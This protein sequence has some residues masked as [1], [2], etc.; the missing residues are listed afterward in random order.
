MTEQEYTELKKRID[1]LN[2]KARDL[3][4]DVRVLRA[5][6][7]ANVEELERRAA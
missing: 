7:R 3:L 2:D 6:L 1:N 4:V 5:E